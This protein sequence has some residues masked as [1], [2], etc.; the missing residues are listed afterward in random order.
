MAILM[1][2]NVIHNVICNFYNT[3]RNLQYGHAINAN[4]HSSTFW[5]IVKFDLLNMR[6]NLAPILLVGVDG[7]NTHVFSVSFNFNF[8][9]LILYK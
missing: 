6:F 7:P 5:S 2:I 4:G 9:L 8:L 1:K 3:E